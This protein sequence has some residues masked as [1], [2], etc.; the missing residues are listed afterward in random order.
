MPFC[1][2]AY[3][4]LDSPPAA[5]APPPQRRPRLDP[6]RYPE[7]ATRARHESLRALAAEYGVSHETIRA[8][9]R[10]VVA[11]RRDDLIA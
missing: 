2:P 8:V 11:H 7:I 4:P 5:P 1:F 9:V 10:R 6:A 3:Y